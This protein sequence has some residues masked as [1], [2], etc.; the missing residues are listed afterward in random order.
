VDL[1]AR[2]LAAHAMTRSM[3]GLGTG[4]DNVATA[5]AFASLKIEHLAR[6]PYRTREAARADVFDDIKRLGKSD[7]MPLG[8]RLS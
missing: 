2:L 5:T 8:R 4:C 7:A 1:R 3:S 6:R